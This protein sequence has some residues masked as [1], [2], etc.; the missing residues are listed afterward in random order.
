MISEKEIESIR[1]N[2][3]ES[4]NPLFL[5]DNDP[6]GFCSALILL[7]N[8]GR[9]KA[10]PIKSFPDF[11]GAIIERIESFLPDSI[12]ILDKP[13]NN[14]EF[15]NLMQEKGVRVFVI[16]HHENKTDE[17]LK[18]KA[19]FFTSYPASEPTSY[20]CQ[21]IYN[22][23]ETEWISLIG[24]IYDIY[25]PDFIYEFEKLYPEMIDSGVDISRI[26]YTS[27][28]GKITRILSLA[29][30]S[31][32]MTIQNYI[33]LFLRVNGPCD[34]LIENE[35]NA[36]LH[37]RY[38]FLS[39]II[40]K[41]IK[42]ATIYPKVVFLEYSG[43]Y[44]LSSDIANY[45]F[46]LHPEKFIV[47]CYKKYESINISLRGEEAK[48][49]TEEIVSTLEGASGGGHEVACGLRIPYEAFGKFKRIISARTGENISKK[50][51]E[52]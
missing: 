42:K 43:E 40:D 2:L 34:I 7:K 3:E 27:D 45:L 21:K 29:L 22:R 24:C 5:F 39:K 51:N 6:D 37:N 8:L 11:D 48:S 41:N 32:N 38:N 28:L 4:G 14:L 36:Y 30:K 10:I 13:F 19:T 46:F 25:K 26:R 15:L 23:K 20:I 18:S 1:N 31:S 47:V 17:E 52:Y 35:K 12:F 44:S 49:I 50:I 16:D 9:G 33:E